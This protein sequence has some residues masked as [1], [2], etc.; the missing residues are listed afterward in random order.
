MVTKSIDQKKASFWAE[1][2]MTGD[3]PSVRSLPILVLKRK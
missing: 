2:F 1:V 3:T